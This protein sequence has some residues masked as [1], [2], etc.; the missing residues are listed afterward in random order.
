MENKLNLKSLFSYRI[1]IVLENT[2]QPMSIRN[3]SDFFNTD[4][5]NASRGIYELARHGLIEKVGN[6]RRENFY[7]LKC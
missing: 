1:L 2:K 7:Y 3:V 5:S 4:R 6:N